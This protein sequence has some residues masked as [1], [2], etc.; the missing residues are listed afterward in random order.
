[1]TMP[2]TKKKAGLFSEGWERPA[3]AWLVVALACGLARRRT[4]GLG[5]E[6]GRSTP[7]FGQPVYSTSGPLECG[8]AELEH[9]SELP[10]RGLHVL[11][12]SDPHAA[13]CEGGPGSS[14]EVRAYVDGYSGVSAVP[15]TLSCDSAL[16]VR[17]WLL[18]P[19]RRAVREQ[20]PK[21]HADLRKRG[22]LQNTLAETERERP[23]PPGL[24]WRLFTPFG[25]GLSSEVRGA[26]EAFGTCSTLYLFEGGSFV[27][28]G[29]REGYTVRVPTGDPVLPTTTLTTLSLQPRVFAVSP[30]LTDLEGAQLIRSADMEMASGRAYRATGG[31]TSTNLRLL[32]GNDGGGEGV[33]QLEIRAHRVLHTPR[34]HFEQLEI[35][36][37]RTGERYKAH[38]DYFTRDQSTCD[39][40]PGMTRLLTDEQTGAERNRLATMLWYLSS[41]SDDEGGGTHFPLAELLSQGRTT[42]TAT[43]DAECGA[44]GLKVQPRLGNASLWYNLRPDGASDRSSK[45]SGCAPRGGSVKWAMNLW[46]WSSPSGT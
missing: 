24:S 27:W 40:D 3:A 18:R 37:Y 1:M 15:L 34:D 9:L 11:T 5:E 25:T 28:P 31:R 36:R 20:R 39:T 13:I 30:L 42:T 26:L 7:G 19:L 41:H 43:S 44:G 17:A 35:L 45:H 6:R 4:E 10:A 32:K 23:P 12:L 46:A 21:V 38:Y 16:S 33:R 29:V 8:P 2:A 14:F 22:L